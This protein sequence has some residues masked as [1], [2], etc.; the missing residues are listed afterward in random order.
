MNFQEISEKEFESIDCVRRVIYHDNSRRFAFI[1]IDNNYG[2]YG[3]SWCSDLIE[4]VIIDE[5]KNSLI[6]IGIDQQL[7]AISR[8]RGNVILSL[9]LTSNLIDILNSDSITAVLTESELFIF[10]FDGSLHQIKALPEIG[11]GLSVVDDTLFVDLIDGEVLSV[12]LK[13]F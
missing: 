12:N 9:Q 2:K 6:W 4:P 8:L 10:N 7:V 11:S 13:G 3:L 5:P 1:E